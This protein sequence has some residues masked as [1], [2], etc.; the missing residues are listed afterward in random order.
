MH[1]PDGFISVPVAVSTGILSGG[2]LWVSLRKSTSSYGSR[3]ASTLGLT[4]AF[5]FSAQMINFPILG[6]TSGHLLGGGLAGALLGCPWSAILSISTVLI[7]QAVLFA[8][9][10]ITALGANILT[11]GIVSVWMSW[12]ISRTLLL[13][14]GGS[15]K[16]LPL[17]C[18]IGS[19][20]SVL[21]TSLACGIILA[22]S[23]TSKAS[24]VIPSMAGIH[25]FIGVGEGVITGSILTYLV[26]VRPDLLSWEEE[27][28]KGFFVPIVL[29]LLIAGVF[30]LF[31]S[32]LPDGLESVAQNLGF[33]ELAKDSKNV[34]QIPFSKYEINGMGQ[35]GKS[36]TGL[37]GA[38]VCFGI[39][40]G[41]ARVRLKKNA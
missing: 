19:G 12:V 30:S 10:G 2:V 34:L 23:G 41:M 8:D 9:G 3:Y 14:F 20:V 17:A 36:T 27:N 6:G 24:I 7:I 26:K 21:G 18:G 16:Y 39:A 32:A 13:L 5:I 11:M 1:L 33:M 15:K 28:F 37:L 35:I 4:T 25:L 31:A 22:I 29:I 38:L 40:Y